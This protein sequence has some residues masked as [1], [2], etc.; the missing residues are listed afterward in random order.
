[1]DYPRIWH[2]HSS[3][4]CPCTVSRLH[5]VNASTRPLFVPNA[6][7]SSVDT[8]SGRKIL[9]AEDLKYLGDVSENKFMT[10]GK[11]DW[12]AFLLPHRDEH[13]TLK[14]SRMQTS[15]AVIMGKHEKTVRAC[16]AVKGCQWT[17]AST[18]FYEATEELKSMKR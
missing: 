12:D 18:L 4:I 13:Q 1:M 7:L 15:H 11:G 10:S 16:E 5:I 6:C 14:Y 8:G 2:R 9:F 3:E 17:E